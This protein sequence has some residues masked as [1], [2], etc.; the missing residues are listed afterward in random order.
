MTDTTNTDIL[1]APAQ[2][3]EV[4]ASALVEGRT[5]QRFARGDDQ[6]EDLA[7][8]LL[9]GHEIGPTRDAV[10]AG[11]RDVWLLLQEVLSQP[12]CN[13]D[14]PAR[15][16]S[17]PV[18]EIVGHFSALLNRAA[19]KE[20]EALV[21]S[22]LEVVLRPETDRVLYGPLVRAALA[23]AHTERRA[24]FWE[25]QAVDELVSGWA[26][27]A[28]AQ[29]N[30]EHPRI[31]RLLVLLWTKAL[32]QDTSVDPVLITNE[33]AAKRKDPAGFRQEVW[34]NVV[35]IAWASGH[36]E[37]FAERWRQVTKQPAED[38][39]T[40]R[41]GMS[42]G[43]IVPMV[44]GHSNPVQNVWPDEL[45]TKIGSRRNPTTVIGARFSPTTIERSE[46][47]TIE[48]ILTGDN[49]K[50]VIARA[51]TAALP[52]VQRLLLV[53]YNDFFDEFVRNILQRASSNLVAQ[54]DEPPQQLRREA[55]V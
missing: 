16:G 42:P 21:Y 5:F 27:K 18:S 24:P 37:L 52:K 2:L 30:A 11:L 7:V 19:P 33:V 17:L 40:T 50:V 8:D 32:A 9:R 48:N 12:D 23:Y 3:R 35:A 53:E 43:V 15:K 13:P 45:V 22:L 51:Y 39:E 46:A 31:L 49:A 29:I 28:L 6:P 55:H 20:L 25:S 47:Y 10:L 36:K 4:V 26:F 41:I 34:K 14:A 54:V 1:L 44:F 38:Q